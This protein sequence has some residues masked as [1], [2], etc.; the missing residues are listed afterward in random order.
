VKAAFLE[1]IGKLSLAEVEKPQLTADDLVQI[2]VKAVGI[3]GSEV[4]AFEGTHPY[5]IPP[6]ILGHEAAG[7]VSAIGKNVSEFQVGDRVLIDPQWVCG[8]CRHCRA[9]DINLCPEK[10]VM[11]TPDWPGAFGE[12]VIAPEDAVYLLPENLTFVQGALIEPLTVAVHVGQRAN[13]QAGQ[14]VAI[15]GSGSI[16]GLVSGICR[17]HGVSPIIVADINEHCLAAPRERLGATH[18]ILLPDAQFVTKVREIAGDEGVDT[19]FI[20]ADDPELVSLGIEM[21]K[22]RGT[23]VLIALLTAEPLKLAAYEI[24]GKE[25]HLIGSSMCTSDDVRRAIDLVASGQID[26]EAI[27]THI[28]PIEDVQHGMELAHSKADDAIKVIL[29]F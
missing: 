14:A 17:V 19:V 8:T 9:G 3:C 26:V 7:I 11:G 18:D 2:Q 21:I 28:L 6:V 23:V 1:S 22:R 24:I 29:E 16:G 25:K 20:C 27:A 4:H 12:Y 10:I 13:L 15:L 5:R